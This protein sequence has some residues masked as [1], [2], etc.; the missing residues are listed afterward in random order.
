MSGTLSLRRNMGLPVR[1]VIVPE[2]SDAYEHALPYT[3]EDDAVLADS[4]AVDGRIVR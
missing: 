1:R 3:A 4:G 2:G